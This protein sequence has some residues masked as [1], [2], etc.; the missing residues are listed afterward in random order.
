MSS[1]EELIRNEALAL[2]RQLRAEPAPDVDGHQL[3]ELLFRGLAP[4]DYDR[5]HSPFLRSTMIMRP[6]EWPEA[7]P[8]V[9]KG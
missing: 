9:R 6:E 5:V 3:L 7:R 2:W 4:G 8:E 1:R